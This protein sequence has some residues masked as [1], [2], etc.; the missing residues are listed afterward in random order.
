MQPAEFV[1]AIERQSVRVDTRCGDGAM[2]WRIWGAGTGRIEEGAT[3]LLFLHG[4]SGS[5]THWIRN[6]P[7]FAPHRTVIAPDLPG[8]GD[9]T[10]LAEPVTVDDVADVVAAGLQQ[11]L[12]P[13][14]R[15]DVVCFSWGS[16]LGTTTCRRL[17]GRVRSLLLVG[18]AG[19]GPIQRS[20]RARPLR[21]RFRGMIEADLWEIN[22]DN[23]ERLMIHDPARIDELAIHLQVTNSARSRFN[24][25]RFAQ[26]TWVVDALRVLAAPLRVIYGEFD[27]LAHENWGDR[28]SRLEAVRPDLEFEI[29]PGAGHWTQYEWD[30]F[31][32]MLGQWLDRVAAG[33]VAG[34]GRAPPA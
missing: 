9:A 23:L 24:S 16:T 19:L 11:V 20:S 25:P 17:A 18:P 1:A 3:P 26:G 4:G 22:R 29:V 14:A 8:L 31:N 27:N 10:A 5:W 12:P 28:R 15:V 13:A 32:A 21:K 2:P 6:I 34:T 7:H 30:G 33:E